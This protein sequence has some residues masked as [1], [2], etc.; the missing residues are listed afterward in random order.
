MVFGMIFP[1]R[2][3]AVEKLEG[4]VDLDKYISLLKHKL[5]PILNHIFGV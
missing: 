3:M 1:S 2:E 5:K 4:K